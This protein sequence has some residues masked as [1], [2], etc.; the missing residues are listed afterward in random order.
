VNFFFSKRTLGLATLLGILAAVPVTASA[1]GLDLPHKMRVRINTNSTLKD[2]QLLAS[3][4]DL[5][6]PTSDGFV[7]A[8]VTPEER[9]YLE[10]SLGY[11]LVVLSEV[12]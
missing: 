5:F 6:A 9:N 12:F 3:G 1:A 11:E 10:E 2:M 8:F 7:E 4:I